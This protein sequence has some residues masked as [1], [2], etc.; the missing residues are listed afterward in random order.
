MDANYIMSAYASL[1]MYITALIDMWQQ[2]EMKL[3]TF[4][5]YT[6]KMKS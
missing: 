6:V 1:C 2:K 5:V 4:A 3:Y